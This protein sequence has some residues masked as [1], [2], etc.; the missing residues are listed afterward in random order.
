MNLLI[1]PWYSGRYH[2]QEMR[3]FSLFLGQGVNPFIYGNSLGE[4]GLGYFNQ[5]GH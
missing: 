4:A 2:I 3:H 5:I 1:F